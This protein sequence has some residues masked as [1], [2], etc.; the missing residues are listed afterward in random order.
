[1]KNCAKKAFTLVELSVVI[2]LI[3]MVLS[4]VA[5]SG[6]II[7]KYRLYSARATTQSSGIM[8]MKNLAVWFDAAS[9]TSFSESETRDG[10]TISTWYDINPTAELKNNATQSTTSYKPIRY[11]NCIN[12]LPCVRFD[13]SDDLLTFDASEILGSD[14]TV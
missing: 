4:V 10:G 14:Y 1:M 12:N 9:D 7:E 11:K 5:A 8:V 3:G 6:S 13:G 2:L